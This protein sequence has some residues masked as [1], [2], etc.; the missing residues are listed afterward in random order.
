MYVAEAVYKVKSTDLNSY[1]RKKK[2]NL[3]SVI[4]V[5]V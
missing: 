2:R 5:S 4:L 1:V 3:K